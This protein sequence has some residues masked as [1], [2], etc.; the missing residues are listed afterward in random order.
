MK[1]NIKIIVGLFFIILISIAY[2]TLAQTL[3]VDKLSKK[4]ILNM[5]YEQLLDMPFE[6]L[7]KLSEKVGLS[8]DDL[9]VMLMNRDVKAASKKAE[10]A[11]ESPLSTTVLNREKIM[12][13]GARNIPEALRLVPGIIVREKTTGNYD[14]HIRGNDNVPNNHLM[15]YSENSISLIMIDGRP[16]FNYA[17]GGTFWETLPVSILDVDRIEVI[18]GPASAL[19]GPNAVSGAI[20]IITRVSQETKVNVN[21]DLQAGTQS[22]FIGNLNVSVPISSKLSMRASGYYHKMDR[23]NEDYFVWYKPNG[24]YVPYDSL[25]KTINPSRGIPYVSDYDQRISDPSM[26]QDRYAAN[27]FMNYNPNSK[28]GL[29][30]SAGM[31]SSVVGTSLLDN[32][33]AAM[34]ERLSDT[35]YLDV[36]GNAYGFNAQI[37]YMAGTQNAARGNEGYTFD[38]NTLNALLE[39]D[40]NLGKLNL[41]PGISYQQANYDD[42]DY[43]DVTIN[44]GI[45]NGK[46]TLSNFSASLRAD[47]RPTDKLRFIAALRAEKYKKPD[48][49][50]PTYQFVGSY[51]LNEN[52]LVRVVYSRANRGPFMSDIYTN[53]DWPFVE[54]DFAGKLPEPLPEAVTTQLISYQG[55]EE[56]ALMKMDMLELGFRN[57]V[58]KN[59]FL[60]LEI[61]YTKSKDYGY[62]MAQDYQFQ[63]PN[64][65]IPQESAALLAFPDL[66]KHEITFQYGN[67]DMISEQLGA[68][69]SLDLIASSKFQIKAFGT[70]QQTFL[71]NYLDRN[72]DQSLLA[73][74]QNKYNEAEDP[75]SKALYGGVLLNFGVPVEAL[76]MVS[77]DLKDME[78]ETTPKF[79]GGFIANYSPIKNLNLNANVYFLTKQEFIFQ[80]ENDLIDSKAILNFKADYKIWKNNSIYFNARNLLGQD[81]REFMFMDKIGSQYLV[82]LSVNF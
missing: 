54:S 36:R 17:H 49:V 25:G 23:H 8:A 69:L 1:S 9:M 82:G 34:S 37:S 46:R 5:D 29:D 13:S 14:V 12:K 42:S 60:D 4:D 77:D 47:Y 56:L 81:H 61:F 28:V 45:F 78:H 6:D 53:F 16:V 2:S 76:G 44:Q 21:A 51:Q 80:H 19:Y 79:Y 48:K 41:R 74:V 27:V 72:P 35:K 18:R 64:E 26:A 55:N 32:S 68:T 59:L 15:F 75:L 31:Q 10:N 71:T 52:N 38:L 3:D 58:T 63:I 67:L 57:K 24:A 50:Y 62:F 73:L 20:N 7:L 43:V 40:W 22:T 33:Y 70:L 30:L 11:I 65:E 39:Y 66:I